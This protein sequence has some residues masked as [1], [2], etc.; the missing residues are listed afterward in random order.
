MSFCILVLPVLSSAQDLIVLDKIVGVVGRNIIKLSD[1]EN[2]H[3]QLLNEGFLTGGDSKCSIIEEMLVQKMLIE[4]SF[5]DSLVVSVA[6][7]DKEIERRIESLSEEIGSVE[8]LEKFY[9]KTILEIKTEWRPL[10]KEQILA[11]KTKQKIIADV[12]V[13]PNEIRKFYNKIP[14]DSLPLINPEYEYAVI[15]INPPVTLEQK[16]A[17]RAKLEEMRERVIKGEKF[18]KLAAMYSDDL[19]SAKKGG[20]LGYVS[21]ADLVTEFAAAAFKLK[22]GEVSRVIESEYG[23][24]IIEMIDKKGEKINCRHILLMPKVNQLNLADAKK[25][26]DS[27][28]VLLKTD[29]LTFRQAASLYSEDDLSKNNSGLAFN[30]YTGSSRFE[31]K[32][33]EPILLHNLKNLKPGEFSAPFISQTNS[34]RQAYSMVQLISKTDAHK[35]SLTGDY[36]LIKDMALDEKRGKMF[37]KWIIEKQRVCYIKLDDSY[38][39]CDFKYPNWV[40]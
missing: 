36:Q 35:A 12:K 18:S 17:L 5:E 34:G 14:E 4:Q 25:K 22:E 28:N 15:S 23:F 13:S 20:D 3:Q 30:P 8:K 19:S 21:R 7:V 33:I 2:H 38:K 39:S 31:G 10:V 16:Q 40:K 32:H 29:T 1:V 26:I 24:H 9:E 11:N 27:I 37:N 6:E